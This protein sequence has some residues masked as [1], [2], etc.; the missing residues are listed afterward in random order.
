MKIWLAKYTGWPMDAVTSFL[1][2][3]AITLPIV[4][5]WNY[6]LISNYFHQGVHIW[7]KKLVSLLLVDVRG[8]RT[9]IPW[10]GNDACSHSANETLSGRDFRTSYDDNSCTIYLNWKSFKI[11]QK[12]YFWTNFLPGEQKTEEVAWQTS[13]AICFPRFFMA[14][15]IWLAAKRIEY[16]P[17]AY[18]SVT[19]TT[20]L[21]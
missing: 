15:E 4:E 1:G 12:S 17:P 13:A 5:L 14:C 19:M 8:I 18:G 16:R 10:S 3:L 9:S 2:T 20:A 7:L 21:L 11:A 6:V